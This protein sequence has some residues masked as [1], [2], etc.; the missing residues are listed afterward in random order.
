MMDRVITKKW[1]GRNDI[2]SSILDYSIA[3]VILKDRHGL[4]ATDRMFSELRHEITRYDRKD[5]THQY[6]FHVW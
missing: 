3:T 2:N 6:K 1:Q 4:F 5:Q